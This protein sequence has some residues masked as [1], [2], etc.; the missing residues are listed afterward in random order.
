MATRLGSHTLVVL[1]L[2]AASGC[3]RSATT[4]AP[5]HPTPV[6]EPDAA[7]PTAEV[8]DPAAPSG[9]TCVVRNA[10][11]HTFEVE[12]AAIGEPLGSLAPGGTL[13]AGGHFAA[14]TSGGLTVTGFCAA[15]WPEVR[16]VEEE[17]ELRAL[18]PEGGAA[19]EG[20]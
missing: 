5:A 11:D 13:P 8:V 4:P 18:S 17:G 9:P 15:A 19:T 1:C 2:L 10:T 20:E 6:E 7:E 14:R 12:D 16:I 3:H